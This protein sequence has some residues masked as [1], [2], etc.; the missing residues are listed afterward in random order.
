VL[1]AAGTVG[2]ECRINGG[3]AYASAISINALKV[4]NLRATAVG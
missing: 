4:T 3:T 1:D 2:V